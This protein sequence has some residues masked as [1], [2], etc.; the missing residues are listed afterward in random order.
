LKHLVI[1]AQKKNEEAFVKLMELNKQGMYKVAK[2]YLSYEEDVADAMQET[3]LTCYEKLDTL[4]NPQYFK[5]WMT[6]IL[7]NKCKDILQKNRELCLMDEMP[8]VLEKSMAQENIEFMELLNSL[9]EKYRTILILYYVEGFKTREIAEILEMNEYTVKTR[10][11]R[12]RKNFAREY[13]KAEICTG[14]QNI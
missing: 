3:I 5:T 9:D 8:E 11:A 14:G 4:R 6:R 1:K 10:L 12:A 13:Q 2:S 7:I